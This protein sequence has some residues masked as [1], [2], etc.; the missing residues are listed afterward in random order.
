MKEYKFTSTFGKKNRKAP[1]KLQETNFL[2]F[3][4]EKLSYSHTDGVAIKNPLIGNEGSQHY[5]CL[6]LT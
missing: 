3:V 2:Q 5:T 1:K 4:S 6:P